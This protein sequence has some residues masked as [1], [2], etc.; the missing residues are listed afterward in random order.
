MGKLIDANQ[1]FKKGLM[2]QLLSGKIRF[3]EFAGSEK[4][5]VKN[6][7]LEEGGLPEG[8]KIKHLGSFGS[9]LKGKG[10]SNSEKTETGIPCITY[11]EIYTRHEVV[12]KGF[13]SF[14]GR[15]TAQKSQRIQRGDILFAGSGETLDEIGKCV[16]HIEDIEAYAGGDIV[17]FRSRG[18]NPLYLSYSLNSNLLIRQKRKLGQGHSVV[19][20]YSA[21]LK[22]LQ[23][24]LPSFEEQTSIA[25]VLS[26]CDREIELLKKKLEKL[27]EQ[28]KG[29]MQKLLTGKIRVKV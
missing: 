16:V 9:F 22:T 20:I 12:I 19:H 4:L 15:D 17:I 6:E 27:K 10:I 1:R 13:N 28:K 26:T 14:V 24:P 25:S 8:W 11:G 21:G 5:K 29:L 3:P 7:K 18:V 2:Q 23:V